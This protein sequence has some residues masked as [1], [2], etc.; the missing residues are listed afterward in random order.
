MSKTI[1]IV[2]PNCKSTN[3]LPELRLSSNPRCGRCKQNLFSAHTVELTHYDFHRHISSN[4]IPVVVD[5]WASWCGPCKIMSPI[6]EQAAAYLE[7]NVRVAKVNTE[8][9]QGLAAK[10]NI[11]SIPT[12]IIFKNGNE[13]SRQSGAM[14]L[15][16]LIQWVRT[17]ALGLE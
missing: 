3:R 14:D 1:H 15:A 9:E 4:Q 12:I 16:T 13:A 10:F 8:T 2:C 11:R 6:L 5:F 7:P 17:N